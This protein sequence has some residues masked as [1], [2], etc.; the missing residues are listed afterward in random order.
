[1]LL[2]KDMLDPASLQT[3]SMCAAISSA[4]T[5][6]FLP[7]LC[8]EHGPLAMT[9][10]MD[11]HSRDPKAQPGSRRL[12]DFASQRQQKINLRMAAGTAPLLRAA[13][14]AKTHD[15]PQP[16]RE[17]LLYLIFPRDGPDFHSL[18]ATQ[19]SLSRTAPRLCGVIQKGNSNIVHACISQATLRLVA[20]A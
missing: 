15:G 13:H 20:L 5:T 14:S 11:L 1:M 8:S 3:T 16:C 6:S 12:I 2:Q 17:Q 18:D 10:I 9:H 7:C 19:G 4:F